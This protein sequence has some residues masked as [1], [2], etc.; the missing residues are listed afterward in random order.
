MSL[1]QQLRALLLKHEDGLT[2]P[3]MMKHLP[4]THLASIHS[5]LRSNSMPDIYID[6]WVK[7]TAAG[8]YSPVFVAVPIPPDAPKP[9][10]S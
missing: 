6:R 4:D 1:T 2:V 7:S 10:R 3:E 5:R 8:G 9:D